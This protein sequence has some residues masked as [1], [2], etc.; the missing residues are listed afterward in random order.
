[1]G[2]KKGLRIGCTA[3][4]LLLAREALV[5]AQSDGPSRASAAPTNEGVDRVFVSPESPMVSLSPATDGMQATQGSAEIA[6]FSSLNQV[7]SQAPAVPPSP[8]DDQLPSARQTPFQIGP[9]TATAANNQRFFEG[10]GKDFQDLSNL[11]SGRFANTKY[12]WYG[13]VRFDGIYDTKPI[14]TTDAFVTS[15]IP[16]PQGR[17]DN[18]AFNPRYSRLGWDTETPWDAM[19]WTIKTRIEVDFFNG[20]SSGAFGS[21][22]LRLRFAWVDVGPFLI[23][24][25]ASLFM[26]Y[27]VFPNVLDY[28][29]PPGMVLMRQ[30]IAAVRIPLADKLKL[31]LGVEQPYSDIQW[32]ENGTWTV[33][34]GN[35]IIT[36]PGVDRNIQ[37]IPDFTGNVR[38]DYKY[39]HVQLAG[40]ARKLTV[41]L[42]DGSENSAFGYGGNLTGT[43]HPWACLCDCPMGDDKTPLEKCRFMG[44]FAGG[45][46]I[47]RYI[48][49]IN[50][51]GLDATFDPVNGFRALS[52]TGW[53]VA[54]EHWWATRWASVFTY[55][56]TN[57]NLTD[58]LPDDTYKSARYVSAN[59][60]WLPVERMGVGVEFLYGSRTDKDGQ[61]G[62]DER[63]QTAFQYKF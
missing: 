6:S 37:N 60:I 20:F 16:V 35:G 27:D 50:G 45:R 8:T 10:G 63:I 41:E 17:G 61:S 55:S 4:L 26:D 62:N 13:F 33:N 32:F 5:V 28:E 52:S 57:V 34:P 9:D 23:G 59:L 54:Y 40:V 56:E 51:L 42:A 36:T 48:Q 15:A 49:D 58:T 7:D 29:G 47:N 25:A 31:S 46:G 11:L 18:M 21:F 30:P 2:V 39:G 19:N 1:M 44:Q 43:Y 53:F 24:Q 38:Y 14:G 3:C 22:P 12:K